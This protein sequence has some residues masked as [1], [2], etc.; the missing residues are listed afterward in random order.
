LGH[1]HVLEGRSPQE[2]KPVNIETKG[3]RLGM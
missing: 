1:A 2:S 3:Q